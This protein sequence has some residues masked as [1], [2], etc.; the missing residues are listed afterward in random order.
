MIQTQNLSQNVKNYERVIPLL[1][2]LHTWHLTLF[3]PSLS[4][5]GGKSSNSFFNH[6]IF[7]N[8]LKIFL[9][10]ISSSDLFSQKTGGQRYMAFSQSQNKFRAIVHKL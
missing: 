9:S 8:D 7:L 1:I 10:Q 6:Q 4:F 5:R 3:L 2:P